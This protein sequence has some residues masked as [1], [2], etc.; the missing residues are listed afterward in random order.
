MEDA[1]PLPDR[2]APGARV[3]LLALLV[4]TQVLLLSL[5]NKLTPAILFFVGLAALSYLVRGRAVEKAF[6]L[7]VFVASYVRYEDWGSLLRPEFC[8]PSLGVLLWLAY[9]A[10]SPATEPRRLSS[11][12]I[13]ILLL[14]ALA[15]FQAAVGVLHERSPALIVRELSYYLYFLVAVVVARSDLSESGIKAVFGA[16]VISTLLI[17]L[18]YF[19][20]Y[21]SFGGTRRPA[22]DQQHMLNIAVPFLAAFYLRETRQVRKLGYGIALILMLFATYITLTRAL[23]IYIPFSLLL[24]FFLLFRHKHVAFPRVTAIVL[25]AT[26]LIVIL[27]K[28]ADLLAVQ[29]R[30][31]GAVTVGERAETF[32]NLSEDLSLIARY[33]LGLQVVERWSRQPILGTGLGDHVHYRLFNTETP[34]Y[35]LD[36]SYLTVLWKLGLVGLIL[37]VGLYAVFLKRVWFV[38]RHAQS[39]FQVLCAAGTFVAFA[40]LVMIGIES[41][42]LIGYRFN[43][44]WA[45][46]MGVFEHWA[47]QIKRGR[48]L[49]G[50]TAAS[51]ASPPAN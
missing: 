24:L 45:I 37:L 16:I 29:R 31:M 25:A 26:A 17:V 41:S 8:F 15:V 5:P 12:E 18:S 50:A 11:L 35:I 10:V 9:R 6:V 28:G 21:V 49:V 51:A 13:L 1:Y 43:L 14:I 27:V 40:A 46:L 47:R 32:R 34:L 3:A 39:D 33:D 20:V 38:Y 44:V 22:S 48:T 19:R 4:A 7:A 30:R 2:L 36:S 23:W 42:I